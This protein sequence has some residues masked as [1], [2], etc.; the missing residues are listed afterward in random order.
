MTLAAF[1]AIVGTRP[2]RKRRAGR[3]RADPAWLQKEL[4]DARPT[5][6]QERYRVRQLVQR[7]IGDPMSTMGPDMFWLVV[8]E[9][10]A[11]AKPGAWRA[12]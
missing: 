11:A 5:R 2:L 8:T 4:G 7:Y 1:A 9:T 6:E 3:R 12:E 10:T